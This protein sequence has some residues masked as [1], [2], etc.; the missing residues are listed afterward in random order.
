MP[1]AQCAPDVT[2][3]LS[4]KY[5]GIPLP[6]SA[7]TQG[8]PPLVGARVVLSG[9]VGW[10]FMVAR[11]V[12]SGPLFSVSQI[13]GDVEWVTQPQLGKDQGWV[14]RR[15]PWDGDPSCTHGIS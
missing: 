15:T 11:G 3:S 10:A 5:K 9:G 1:V 14:T 6:V 2:S 8:S 12:G 4:L 7:G 13:K